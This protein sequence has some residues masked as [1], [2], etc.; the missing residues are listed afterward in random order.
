MAAVAVAT[1]GMTETLTMSAKERRR[2]VIMAHVKT[3]HL[4]LVAAAGVLGLSYRQAKR[5]WRRYAAQ[6]DA[7]L[8]HRHRGQPGRRRKPAALRAK[9]LA[10]VAARYPDFGPTL[11]AEYLAQEKLAVDHETLRRWLLAAGRR[12]VRRRQ[13]KHR[14]WRERKPCFGALVQLERGGEKLRWRALPG[15]PAPARP[16]PDKAAAAKPPTAAWKPAVDHPW[17]RQ[18]IGSVRKLAPP[19]AR[20]QQPTTNEGDIFS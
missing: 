2:A 3:G 19:A 8:V 9:I 4:K 14:Q 17:R 7:G 18:R 6:G 15:R 5:V 20:E 16:K 10:R 13:Q 11:A 12:T 1:G